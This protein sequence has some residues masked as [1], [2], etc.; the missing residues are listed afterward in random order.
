MACFGVRVQGRRVY[1]GFGVQV[2][3]RRI[4]GEFALG[5]AVRVSGSTFRK[6]F[7]CS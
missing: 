1:G 4:Y 7:H 2:Q 5:F 6:L 3:G